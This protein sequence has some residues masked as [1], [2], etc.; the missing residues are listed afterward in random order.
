MVSSVTGDTYIN[1]P[2]WVS[3]LH[4][5]PVVSNLQLV[6][7]ICWHHRVVAEVRHHL[8]PAAGAEAARRRA[9]GAGH[10]AEGHAGGEERTEGGG[11]RSG[12]L[13]P[14]ENFSLL[15][16]THVLRHDKEASRGLPSGSNSRS[17]AEKW[18]KTRCFQTQTLLRWKKRRNLARCVPA[19][20]NTAGQPEV[21][22]RS[23][24]EAHLQQEFP[25]RFAQHDS[26][27]A[28]AP[29]GCSG[30]SPCT[31]RRHMATVKLSP[32]ES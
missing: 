6:D 16:R 3:T 31:V 19:A 24:G 21:S 5:V 13:G 17:T 14:G 8:S 2:A 1:F 25:G 28:L 26:T 32:E 27:I 29:D 22:Q 12:A 9:A 30:L 7:L 10:R 15:S 20:D 23:E 11:G 18:G 4:N